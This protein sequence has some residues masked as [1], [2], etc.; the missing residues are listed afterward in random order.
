VESPL[1]ANSPAVIETFRWDGV[2]FARLPAHL[3]RARAT[4]ARLGLPFDKPAIDAALANAPT[5]Q[6][7]RTRLLIAANG[8]SASFAEMP[9]PASEWQLAL[10]PTQLNSADPWL[11]MKT[12]QRPLYDA[13]RAALPTGIDEYIFLNER[14]ELCEGTITNLFVRRDGTL[15]TPARH[16]GLLPG[17]LRAEL[18]AER[19]AVEAVLHL[20]DLTNADIFLGNALRG[21]VPAQLTIP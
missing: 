18:L 7:A 19:Q 5:G 16:C 6:P 1:R 20:H 17:I 8:P 13:A 9:V 2:A 11:Q 12:T 10:H 15:L 4:C 21:L 14:G 3:A